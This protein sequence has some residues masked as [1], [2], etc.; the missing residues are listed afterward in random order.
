MK[1]EL[2][3]LLVW[4]ISTV[5]NDCSQLLEVTLSAEHVPVAARAFLKHEF[6]S[7]GVRQ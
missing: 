2:D 7:F 4:L 3:L 1:G 6:F 5:M